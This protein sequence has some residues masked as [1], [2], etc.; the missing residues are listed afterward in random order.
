VVVVEQSGQRTGLVVDALLGEFQ[1]V[2]KPLGPLFT[3]LKCVSGSTILGNG[4]VALI[5]DVGPLVT[6]YAD[7]ERTRRAAP[8]RAR[9]G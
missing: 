9:A 5:L 4:D 6:E 3:N 7:R 1:T 8:V 2:I